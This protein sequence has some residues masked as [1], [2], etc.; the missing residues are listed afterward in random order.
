MMAETPHGLLLANDF[1]NL[2][3]LK[4]SGVC[5]TLCPELTQGHHKT[6]EPR[7]R[8]WLKRQND[9]RR[10]YLPGIDFVWKEPEVGMKVCDW[11][12]IT[13]TLHP[14]PCAGKKENKVIA[15][16]L[17]GLQFV[18]D[19]SIKYVPGW[20]WLFSTGDGDR[21]FF[22]AHSFVILEYRRRWLI[23]QVTLQKKTLEGKIAK[24]LAIAPYME[25]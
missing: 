24:L 18:F 4:D 13:L 17:H 19:L 21:G 2:A 20:T 16:E 25:D 1:L 15:Y 3:L 5:V 7:Y 11:R 23:E 14:K 8:Y 12:D 9:D 10:V 6:G 22:P